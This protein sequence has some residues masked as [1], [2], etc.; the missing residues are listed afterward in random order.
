M[1]AE[2]VNVEGAD[3]KQAESVFSED[4]SADFEK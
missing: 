2:P 1:E 3:E 4:F